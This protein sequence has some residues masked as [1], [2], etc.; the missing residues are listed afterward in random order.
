MHFVSCISDATQVK[1]TLNSTFNINSKQMQTEVFSPQL[2]DFVKEYIRDERAI[3]FAHPTIEHLANQ[4]CTRYSKYFRRGMMSW[5]KFP[6]GT[7]NFEFE[8]PDN[9]RGK[10]VVMIFNCQTLENVMDQY[11]LASILPRQNIKRLDIVV[12]FFGLG[13]MERVEKEGIIASAEPCLKLLSSI[14]P[15]LSGRPSLHF[16]DIHA[17]VERFYVK[18]NCIVQM[19]TALPALMEKITFIDPMLRNPGKKDFISAIAFPDDGAYKRFAKMHYFDG[20]PAI[21]CAKIRDGNT[22]KVIIR[23]IVRDTPRMWSGTILII[24][25]LVQSGGTL[26]QCRNAIIDHCKGEVKVAAFV[27]HGVFP[28][29]SWKNFQDEMQNTHHFTKFYLS[30]SIPSVNDLR[31]VAPFEVLE[32]SDC[33][34]LDLQRAITH[35]SELSKIEKSEIKTDYNVFVASGNRDKLKA[36]FSAFR[37]FGV[38]DE[39]LT[40]SG[41]TVSSD[42]SDQPLG[43]EETQ[44]GALNRINAL[45]KALSEKDEKW[46]E[47]KGNVFLVSM[48][49]GIIE[50]DGKF[51]DTPCVIVRNCGS[52]KESTTWGDKIEVPAEFVKTVKDQEQKITVGSLLNKEFGWSA[53][54]WHKYLHPENL[55]RWEII[56]KASLEGIKQV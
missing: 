23:D 50:Q 33:I 35:I 8:T 13:T 39:F 11:L 53:S 54:S 48:E 18:E 29:N 52:S 6:D 19:Q 32:L 2:F 38:T 17:I 47:N 10:N 36:A 49:N 41:L 28:K 43:T 20:V 9:L 1:T 3:V 44:K 5:A 12:P 56:A 21:I 27:S 7:P 42:V 16:Y 22:R 14:E 46:K 37:R 45:E 25:D 34:A 30:N 26:V 55:D 4:L 40:V 31:N 15:T 51:Y 24:D